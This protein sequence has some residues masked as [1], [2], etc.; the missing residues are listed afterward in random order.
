MF[1]YNGNIHVD[2]PGVGADEPL[3]SFFFR[4]INSKHTCVC[5]TINAHKKFRIKK[6]TY[7]TEQNRRLGG[8]VYI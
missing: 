1:E 2:W 6:S 4:I 5:L 8:H 7:L 3:G